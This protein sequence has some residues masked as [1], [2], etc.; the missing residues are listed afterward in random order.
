MGYDLQILNTSEPL[1]ITEEQ[2]KAVVA[3]DKELELNATATATNPKSN[4]VI[5]VNNPLMSTWT[6][7]I[8][9]NK[10]YFYYSRGKVT[11]KNPSDSTIKKM[12][13]IALKIGAKVQGEEGE[14]Y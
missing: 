5:Q 10:N 2:W 11:V 9:K 12:K 7:P 14:F 13:E 6:D 3:A 1:S 4:E 8:S